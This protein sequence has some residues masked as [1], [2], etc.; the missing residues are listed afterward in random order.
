MTEP[1]AV[2]DSESWREAARD[3]LRQLMDEVLY[4]EKTH[5]SAAER[6]GG[7]HTQL[8]L[9]ATISS[10]LAA[11]SLVTDYSKLVAGFF[12]LLAALFSALL[13]FLKPE[14]A[15]EQHL[16]AGRQLAALRVSLRQ[17]LSL[18][19][20]ISDRAELRQTIADLSGQKAAID[21]DAPGT[22][23]SDFEKARA[24]I[25]SGIFDRDR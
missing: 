5:L 9:T 15:A 4:T 13:T 19:S 3:E 11:A 20:D 7:R 16:A 23:Q 8:G 17:S 14:R 6:L 12:A 10:V 22:R 1:H 25:K 21:A 24:K 18:D 2:S